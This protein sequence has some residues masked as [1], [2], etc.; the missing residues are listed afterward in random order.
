[1]TKLTIE[2]LVFYHE[3]DER[4]FFAWLDTMAVVDAFEGHGSA[5]HV[6]LAREPTDEDL[7]EL[8]AFHKRYG[9]E[10]RQLAAFRRAENETWFAAAGTYW[11]EA[12]FGSAKG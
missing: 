9:I 7:R 2:S 4:D 8:L 10:M 12:V 11:H 6:R 5:L 3:R 1:M